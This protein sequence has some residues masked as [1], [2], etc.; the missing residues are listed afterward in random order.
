MH[1]VC[2]M[3]SLLETEERQGKPQTDKEIS[4]LLAYF[5]LSHLAP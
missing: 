3:R 2:M 4:T 5:V 1:F